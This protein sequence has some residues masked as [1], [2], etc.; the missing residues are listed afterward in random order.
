MAKNS[1]STKKSTSSSPKGLNGGGNF[2]SNAK[3]SDFEGSSFGSGGQ[4][5][6][7]KG[8]FT[9]EIETDHG[10]NDDLEME[11]TIITV[12]MKKGTG[13]SEII[14]SSFVEG[15]G[16]TSSMGQKTYNNNPVVKRIE[17]SM[18]YYAELANKWK[19]KNS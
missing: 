10:Y 5:S 7:T 8:N 13:R 18:P 19:K 12:S 9:M 16:L 2:P 3:L 11:G 14:N 4:Y 15:A 6:L 1:G 17:N